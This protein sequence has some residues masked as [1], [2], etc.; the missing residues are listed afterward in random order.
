[1]YKQYCVGIVLLILFSLGI[2]ACSG[3]KDV[4]EMQST[5]DAAQ[6]QLA[7]EQTKNVKPTGRSIDHQQ[8]QQE[9]N[10]ITDTPILP[11]PTS[12][13]LELPTQTPLP[14]TDTPVPS[15]TP[16][17]IPSITPT[18]TQD[19]N[20]VYS[21]VVKN[22]Y[23]RTI[24]VVFAGKTLTM[25]ASVAEKT[26]SVKAGTQPIKWECW[27]GWTTGN[28]KGSSSVIVNSNLTL[29]INSQCGLEVR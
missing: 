16:S 28:L 8:N 2:Q 20:A 27:T 6:T 4:D 22:G 23:G 18:P 19:P 9:L 5:L 10:Q 25:N 29:K 13:L 24:W 12:I 3:N 15:I 11:S 17:P 1:M 7:V 21:V 26:L 14:G